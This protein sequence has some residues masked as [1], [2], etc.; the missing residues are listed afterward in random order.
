MV[1]KFAPAEE[2]QDGRGIL[3]INTFHLDDTH[4]TPF[5]FHGLEV[6]LVTCPDNYKGG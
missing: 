5:T 1:S 2:E 6:A 4:K 3:V